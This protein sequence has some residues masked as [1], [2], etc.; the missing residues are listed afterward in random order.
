M[1]SLNVENLRKLINKL[2]IFTLSSILIYLILFWAGYMSNKYII[3]AFGVFRNQHDT[4]PYIFNPPL[5]FVTLFILFFFMLILYVIVMFILS[6][7]V[8]FLW[9]KNVIEFTCDTKK[10]GFFEKILRHIWL[11]LN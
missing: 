6:L 8:N 10:I 9:Q 7:I 1:V 3:K 11:F 4:N 2:F 5:G